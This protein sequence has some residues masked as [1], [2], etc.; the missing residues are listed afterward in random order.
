M[1]SPAIQ[2]LSTGRIIRWPCDPDLRGTLAGS[3]G[4]DLLQPPASPPSSSGFA[5]VTSRIEPGQY[6]PVELRAVA[7]SP[8]EK[9][10]QSGLPQQGT[11]FR[12]QE[13]VPW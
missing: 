5:D 2:N 13:N 6:F 9:A 12:R 1:P 3:V 4:V 7:V 11:H 8:E 10:H